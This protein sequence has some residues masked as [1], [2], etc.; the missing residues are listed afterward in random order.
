MFTGKWNLIEKCKAFQES[1]GD[2]SL[3]Q[4]TKMENVLKQLLPVFPCTDPKFEISRK[5]FASNVPSLLVLSVCRIFVKECKEEWRYHL[6]AN[7]MVPTPF[8]WSPI[9]FWS[10]SLLP[11]SDKLITYLINSDATKSN[12]MQCSFLHIF[13]SPSM[14][15]SPIQSPKTKVNS[16]LPSPGLFD[17]Y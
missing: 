16:P 13:L 8:I 7:K 17:F 14:D 12:G 6:K 3:H 5:I 11:G 1:D 10:L 9:L 15:S 2:H 4:Q